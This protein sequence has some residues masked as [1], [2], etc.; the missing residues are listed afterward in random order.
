MG[1]ERVRDLSRV[2]MY[3]ADIEAARLYVVSGIRVLVERFGGWLG[4]EHAH[5]CAH[6]YTPQYGRLRSRVFHYFRRLLH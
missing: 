1:E 3:D 6:I 2:I 4:H 5:A